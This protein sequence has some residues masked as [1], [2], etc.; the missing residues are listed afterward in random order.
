MYYV[1]CP[2][3]KICRNKL[4]RL[5]AGRLADKNNTVLNQKAMTFLYFKLL[6]QKRTSVNDFWY[7]ES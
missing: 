1:T 4:A 2:L 7:T 3:T 5:S 6:I